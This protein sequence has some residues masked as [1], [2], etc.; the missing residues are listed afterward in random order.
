VEWRCWNPIAS[1]GIGELDLFGD[2][3]EALVAELA[4]D[5]RI[6]ARGLRQRLLRI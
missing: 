3:A 1:A 6:E 5:A 2:D 4:N